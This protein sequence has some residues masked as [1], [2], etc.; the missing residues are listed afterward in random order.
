M[1]KEEKEALDAL[2]EEVKELRELIEKAKPI[3]QSD[4]LHR[5]DTL[6][7][8]WRIMLSVLGAIGGAVAVIVNIVAYFNGKH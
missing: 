2:K 3:I 6:I 8:S 1:T 4:N 7:S 5:L